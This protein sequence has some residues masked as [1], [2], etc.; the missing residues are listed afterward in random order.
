MGHIRSASF[1]GIAECTPYLRTSYEQEATTPRSRLPPIELLQR[2]SRYFQVSMD[3]LV[4][5]DLPQS[6]IE[7]LLKLPD[8]Q[9]VLPVK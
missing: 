6:R 7:E 3:L 9:T 1:I 8:Y 2:I 4:G 5:I